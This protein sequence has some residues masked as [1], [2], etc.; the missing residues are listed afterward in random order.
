MAALKRPAQ[1]VDDNAAKQARETKLALMDGPE[2]TAFL[3]QEEAAAARKDVQRLGLQMQDT[4]DKSAYDAKAAT[5][6]IYAKHQ[7][8]IE[9]YRA[10]EFA[11]GRIPPN[12]EFLLKLKLGDDALK[13][14]AKKKSQAEKR[15]AADRVDAA[16]GTPQSARSDT[17]V[18]TGKNDPD[19]L[20]AITA[21]IHAEERRRG[22]RQ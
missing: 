14:Q 17:G 21:R 4:L 15:A 20:E 2:K 11:A 5:N 19:S 3:A 6:P 16:K 1:S 10:S 7:A 8:A 22:V 9:S 18:K 12:R 13:P